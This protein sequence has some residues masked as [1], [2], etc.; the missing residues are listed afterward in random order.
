MQW[1]Q[2]TKSGALL[3]YLLLTSAHIVDYDESTVGTTIYQS[4]PAGL[5][6]LF[7]ITGMFPVR[8]YTQPDPPNPTRSQTDVLWANVMDESKI[9]KAIVPPNMIPCM[10]GIV[11]LQ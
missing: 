11:G 9:S 6:P 1:S 4:T 2:H 10:H 8:K 7:P 3:Q 5:T